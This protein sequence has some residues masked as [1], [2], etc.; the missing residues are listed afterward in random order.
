[1]TAEAK[2]QASTEEPNWPS[3]YHFV[4]TTTTMP[5]AP[6]WAMESCSFSDDDCEPNACVKVGSAKV[7]CTRNEDYLSKLG[8][9]R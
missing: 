6:V 9:Q 1:M 8:Q 4:L 2:S 5:S 3:Q 7:Y